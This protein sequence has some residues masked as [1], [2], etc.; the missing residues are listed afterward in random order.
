MRQN[1]N[2]Q[3][4]PKR[5][6][7]DLAEARESAPAEIFFWYAVNLAKRWYP[8]LEKKKQ[9]KRQTDKQSQQQQIKSFNTRYAV[10]RF[11]NNQSCEYN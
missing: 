9:Q 2:I 8:P 6:L 10:T 3:I 7:T 1:L 11:T 5:P 4:E